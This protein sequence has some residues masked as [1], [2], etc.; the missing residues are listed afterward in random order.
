MI[1]SRSYGAISIVIIGAL[2]ILF[3]NMYYKDYHAEDIVLAF[4]LLQTNQK[5]MFTLWFITLIGAALQVVGVLVMLKI[6]WN[7]IKYSNYEYNLW[8]HILIL[9]FVL[10]ISIITIYFAVKAIF[11]L[12]FIALIVY[13]LLNESD[14]K[15]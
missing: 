6:T 3:S 12:V 1:N 15:R 5:E 9:L 14:N 8:L 2:L 13:V 11:G 7:N 10:V 4:K